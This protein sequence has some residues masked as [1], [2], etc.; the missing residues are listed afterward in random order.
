M[1]G[2]TIEVLIQFRSEPKYS[3]D[4]QRRAPVAI[5]HLREASLHEANLLSYERRTLAAPTWDFIVIDEVQDFTTAQMDLVLGTLKEPRNF[6]LCGDA[7]QIV[8]PNFF[9]WSGLKRH[10]CAQETSDRAADL[11]RVLHTNYRNARQVTEAANRILRL[12]HARF[13]SVDKESN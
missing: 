7:N 8:H 1:S 6:I 5:R 13:R 10:F 11:I 4:L 3:S 9:S 2:V 12:K